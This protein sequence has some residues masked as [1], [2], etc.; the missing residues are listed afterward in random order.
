MCLGAC[1]ACVALLAG[2]CGG[3][4]QDAHEPKGTFTVRV[5]KA[6][7]PARQAVARPARLELQVQNTGAQTV[8]NVAVT[9]D[10]FY[11]TENYPEL[12]ANKR[13]IWAIEEGPGPISKRPVPSQAVSPPGGGQTAYVNTWALGSL[14]PGHTQTFLWRVMPVKPGLHTVNF[15]V[16]AGLAG[17]ARA[18]ADRR[19]V[20]DGALPTGHF[21]V[22]IAPQPPANH[23]DPETGQIVSGAYPPAP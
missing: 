10:S 4:R 8:P 7:F 19:S 18:L 13:P 3:A 23:V 2:G 6:S 5:V 15:T 21:T 12:A 22:D 11:Y 14:A 16:A 9:I 1:G 17:N 20:A